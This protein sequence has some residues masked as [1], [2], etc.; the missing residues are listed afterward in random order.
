[1]TGSYTWFQIQ[2]QSTRDIMLIISLIEKH[3]LAIRSIGGKVFQHSVFVNSMFRAQ[4]FPELHSNLV[5]A[6][7]NLQ[8]DNFTWH[9]SSNRFFWFV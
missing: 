3:I 9:C 6:L 7:S 2:Q 5:S 1:M 4:A 8:C